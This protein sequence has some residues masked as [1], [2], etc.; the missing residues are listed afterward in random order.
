MTAMP[1]LFL[2]HGSPL[3]AVDPGG[4]GAS[5]R[6]LAASLPPPRAILVASA[7][8]ETSLPML[9]SGERPQTIHD[10]SGFPQELYS[11]RYAAP[12]SPAV[13]ARAAGLLRE[14]GFTPAQNGCRGLDHGAWVPLRWMYPEADVPIVQLSVQPDLGPL[15]HLRL[16]EALAPLTREGV[17]V[18]GS[19]HV[20]HNLADWS[21]F[22]G[23]SAA[24]G[25]VGEFRAW[26]HDRLVAG[27]REALLRYREL[28]P[29]AAR[30]HPTEEHF[31]PLFVAL[32]AAG[33][34]SAA[35]RVHEGAEGVALAMD[36]WRFG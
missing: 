16:G 14:A 5:W 24:L 2:S 15:H 13:A 7:H 4:A 25:Y 1:S 26:L 9:T 28:A 33:A 21:R 32:G 23:E 6:A 31:L 34:G 17:L 11:I 36:A 19:G 27:D 29:G 30:A 35:R 20:T 12:G 3:H 22:R 18:I 8:W 10:F